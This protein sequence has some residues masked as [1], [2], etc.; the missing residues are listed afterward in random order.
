M[1]IDSPLALLD[2]L[3]RVQLLSPEQA[4]EAARE[5]LPHFGSAKALGDY[6]VEVDWL[7]SYQ[8]RMLLSDRA[9]ELLV[10]PFQVLDCLGEGGVSEVF[11]AWDTDCGRVVA[12]K[13][14]RQ[15]FAT[16]SGMVHQFQR[17]LK[18]LTLLAHPNIVKTY[19]AEPDG[20][21]PYLAM[22]Y[23]EGMDLG[24]FVKEAGTLNVEQACD[25]ARQVA[26]GLQ[27]AHQMGL[28]H[29]DIKPSN[30]FLLNPPL[31]SSESR[32]WRGSGSVVKIIDWGLARCVRDAV[33]SGSPI[34][35]DS[36]TDAEKRSLIGTA[37]F[38]APEQALD[39]T[40]ADIRSDIYS[41]GC[42][43]FYLLTGQPPFGGTSVMQ[44]LLQHQE[45]E[46]PSLKASRPDVPEELDTLIRRMMARDPRDRF[47]IPLLVVAPLRRFTAIAGGCGSTSLLGSSQPLRPAA[48]GTVLNLPRPLTQTSIARPG[49]DGNLARP[50]SQR[51]GK[52]N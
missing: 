50:T 15:H 26:Q 38:V 22:E 39:P 1:C 24:R 43:L 5:L 8:L 20:S 14:L 13:V 33:Q 25:Y 44:K 17:E 16:H 45:A 28:V 37:D 12:L 40:L 52:G 6:L 9:D 29:R 2:V 42:S 4:D 36:G 31:P 10:G 19:E 47:A 46:R 21:I 34:H 11:R 7:T 30:L 18:A 3:R 51:S 49:T 23:I 27:H 48:P 35:A 32:D 41:L